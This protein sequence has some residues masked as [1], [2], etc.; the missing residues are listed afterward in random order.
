MK[1]SRPNL[2]LETETD[3]LFA[4]VLLVPGT[5]QE[6]VKILT[7]SDLDQYDIIIEGEKSLGSLTGVLH[8]VPE[9]EYPLRV[10]MASARFRVARTL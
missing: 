2:K 1:K 5:D 10:T 4:E 6:G 9:R 8:K 3:I 7:H